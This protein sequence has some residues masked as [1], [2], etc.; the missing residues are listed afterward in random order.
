[1]VQL[2]KVSWFEGHSSQEGR[3]HILMKFEVS[4]AYIPMKFRVSL[5]YT[6]MKFSFSGLHT[7]EIQSL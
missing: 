6:L 5:A 1:M 7:D 4:L 2:L 3:M